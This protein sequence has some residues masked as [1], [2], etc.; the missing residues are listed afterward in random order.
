MTCCVES[1]KEAEQKPSIGQEICET[2]GLVALSI[3]DF[4]QEQDK[5]CG[6]RLEP[7]LFH[8]R[9]LGVASIGPGRKQVFVANDQECVA[10]VRV[11]LPSMERGCWVFFFDT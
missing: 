2:I 9:L 5:D 7:L 10:V 6:L 8:T 3:A 1:T 4:T 11:H